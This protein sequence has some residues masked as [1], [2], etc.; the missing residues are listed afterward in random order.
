MK[1]AP[2]PNPNNITNFTQLKTWQE[3]HKLAIEIHSITKSFPKEEQ[4][5]LTDQ[6]R[7]CALSVSSNIAEGFSRLTKKDKCHFY[8]IAKGSLTELQ[9][10]LLYARDVGYINSNTFQKIAQESVTI[11]KLITGL[12]HS[13]MD[14]Q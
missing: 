5:S 1:S 11:S 3:S 4:Y 13:A 9:N 2:I 14:K 8:A 6:I 10:Q 12:S 7:R